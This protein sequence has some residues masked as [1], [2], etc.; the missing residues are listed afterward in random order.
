M[1]PATCEPADR[2]PL[3]G[4]R[5]L[6]FTRVLAGPYATALMAD[7]DADVIKV[8]PP[9]GDD[10]RHIGPFHENG[11]SALFEAVNRSK[12]SVMLDLS[13]DD[14]RAVARGLAA[15]ADVV[16]ENFRPGVADRL[17]IGWDALSA[18]NPGLVYASISGFGQDGPNAMRPAYD[19][20]VQAMSGIMAVT[21][22]AD[23]APTMVGE[24]IADVV[25]GLFGS[26]SI[27]AALVD[28]ERSGK[29]RRLDV[30][31]F[32]SMLALQPIMIAR[33]LATGVAPSRVGNRHALSAP[34]GAFAAGDGSF[35]LAVLNDK[36]F[37]TLSRAIGRPA[38]TGDARFATDPLRLQ[39]EPALR[40]IIE[41]WSLPLS[42]EAAV[43]RLIGE[44]VPAA[45]VRNTAEALSSEQVRQRPVLQDAAHPSRKSRQVPEQPV[46]FSGCRRGEL[47][48]AP[49]LGEHTEDVVAKQQEAWR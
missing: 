28:R 19:I 5:V 39:N 12:R 22:E 16:V 17:G 18:T 35:V 14:D 2:K 27:L 31:M 41:E 1:S 43:A 40:T 20:I 36:L 13:N 44:G 3:E 33:Y 32:D 48:A 38:L 49:S 46:R 30:S 45:A 8:E 34:F 15:N 9:T 47:R 10:Y 23:G 21:G 24:S 29:G 25:S 6:D 42:V 26:W 7:L 11:S 4:I 37:A